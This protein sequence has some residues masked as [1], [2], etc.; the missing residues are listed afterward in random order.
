[1]DKIKLNINNEKVEFSIP[2]LISELEDKIEELNDA[3]DELSCEEP[4]DDCSAR[5]ERWMDKMDDLENSRDTFEGFQE[6]LEKV[7]SG[8][9]TITEEDGG[10]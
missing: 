9:I 10:K 5:Y 3:I 2:D 6:Y 7:M 1:M 8:E 4:E